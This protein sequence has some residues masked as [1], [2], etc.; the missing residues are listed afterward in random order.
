[1]KT[2]SL[3]DYKRI[4]L[5]AVERLEYQVIISSELKYV[6]DE[7]WFSR[8]RAVINSWDDRDDRL[9]IDDGAYN[10]FSILLNE[11]HSEILDKRLARIETLARKQNRLRPYRKTRGELASAQTNQILGSIFEIN[12]LSAAIQSCSSIELFPMTG[13]GGSD[14]DAKLIVDDRAIYIEAKALTYSKHDVAAPYSGYVGLHSVNSM[15]KQVYDALN[16]KLMKGRQLHMLS[17]EFPTVL[18]LSLGYNADIHS[19]SWAIESYYQEQHSNVS[20]VLVFGS[21]L[22]RDSMKAFPNNYS[23]L[24]LSKKEAILFQTSFYKNLVNDNVT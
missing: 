17:D 24:P 3:D 23:L 6:L 22:C 19:C 7:S 18:F 20:S 10:L 2:L 4:K 8:V 1:M 5:D 14:V 15:L 9:K 12:I 13:N 21:A 16:E 11:F